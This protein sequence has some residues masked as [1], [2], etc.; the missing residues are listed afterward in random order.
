MDGGLFGAVDVVHTARVPVVPAHSV[1]FYLGI[2]SGFKGAC[3]RFRARYR[4]AYGRV[5]AC[6]YVAFARVRTVAFAYGCACAYGRVC[7]PLRVRIRLR[8]RVLAC[9]NGRASMTSVI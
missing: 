8:L 7:I 2:N 6:A 1:R 4:G 9:A 5:C 3:A